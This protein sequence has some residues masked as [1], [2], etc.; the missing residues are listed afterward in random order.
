MDREWTLSRCETVAEVAAL[1]ADREGGDG[2]WQAYLTELLDRTGLLCTPGAAFGSLGEGYVRFALVQ[3]VPVMEEIVS[4]VAA[5]GI[6]T[7]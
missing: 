3:P 2:G 7:R 5:S 4:A 1:L 6:L